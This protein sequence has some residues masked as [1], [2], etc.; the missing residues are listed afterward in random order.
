[1]LVVSV[2]TYPALLTATVIVGVGECLHTTVL[3][4]LTADL[5]PESLRGRYMASMGLSWWIGLAIAPA[6]GMPFLDRAASAVFLVAAGVA[7]AAGVAALR[8]G[9]RLPP[10]A[11]VTPAARLT[12]VAGPASIGA[13]Q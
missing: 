5:A 2:G 10:A 7:L 3:M 4:P 9:H 8:L 12:P 1:M 6:V 11:R 13:D